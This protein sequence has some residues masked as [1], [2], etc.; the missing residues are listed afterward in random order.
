MS[1]KY[2]VKRQRRYVYMKHVYDNQYEYFGLRKKFTVQYLKAV[3]ND[4]LLKERFFKWLKNYKE[5][6]KISLKFFKEN[7]R[8]KSDV[9]NENYLTKY[10]DYIIPGEYTLNKDYQCEQR[11][12]A[13]FVTLYKK[14]K[15]DFRLVV[16]YAYHHQL[17]KDNDL[18]IEFSLYT[19][20]EVREK[21]FGYLED[22]Q[23]FAI[24]L[25]NVLKPY[26]DYFDFGGLDYILVDLFR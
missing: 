15:R 21:V 5:L 10:V 6:N 26:R 12:I 2:I 14:A 18:D 22:G 7:E 19:V 8:E 20:D 3:F 17:S 4:K 16:K 25:K 1:Y 24:A 13:N 23:T 9:G 11:E